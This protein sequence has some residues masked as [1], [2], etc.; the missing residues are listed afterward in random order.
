M[1]HPVTTE[2]KGESLQCSN[3]D[4]VIYLTAPAGFL[5]GMGTDVGTDRWERVA[6]SYDLQCLHDPSLG[7][8]IHIFS[9]LHVQRACSLAGWHEAVVNRD[10][11]SSIILVTLII[12]SYEW[13]HQTPFK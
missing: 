10:I 3:S 12:I 11:F 9:Y 13:I 4:G 8:Q 2:F 1:D 6:T 5:A 7:N